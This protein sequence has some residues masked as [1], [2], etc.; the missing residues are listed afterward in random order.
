MGQAAAHVDSIG[1]KAR[2]LVRLVEAG[3][4]VPSFVCVTT[5]AMAEIARALPPDVRRLFAGDEPVD[6]ARAPELADR[7][8]TAILAIGLPGGAERALAEEIER[9]FPADVALAVR[10]SAV[11]EDSA[12]DSFAGQLDTF[13]WVARDAVAARVLDCLAS[14]CSARALLY[15][16]ARLVARPMAAAVVVQRMVESRAAGIMFTADPIDGDRARLLVVAG[17]GLG[18]GVVTDRVATDRYVLSASN[19]TVLERDVAVKRERV[20]PD[21]ARGGTRVGA[22]PD[23]QAAS[24][25]LFDAELRAL[26]DMAR[27]VGTAIGP[28]QDVEWAI[29]QD[30]CLHFLQV[31]PI[32]TIDG[33]QETVFDNANIVE[34]YPGFS[35]PLTFSFARVAYEET[36]RQAGRLLGVPEGVLRANRA[37][38]ANMIAHLRGRIY[39][40]LTSFYRVMQLV[41]GFDWV[42]PAWEK[43]L[44]LRRAAQPPPAT[45]RA[46][47]RSLPLTASV[48][49]RLIREVVTL[50]GNVASYKGLFEEVRTGFEAT[51]LGD[52]D[53]HGLLRL[54]ERLTDRLLRPYAVSVIN[55][56]V[57]QQLF[58]AL[59]RTLTR[60]GAADPSALR[61]DLLSGERA[62]ESL[63]PAASLLAIAAEVRASPPLTALFAETVDDTELWRRARTEPELARL[64]EAILRH[65]TRY[66][67]RTLHELKLE[68]PSAAD[69]P[70]FVVPLIRRYATLPDWAA[71]LGAADAPARRAAE[72]E[73]RRLL[74]RQPFGRL[75]F[76]A[77]LRKARRAVR[78]REDLRLL[79]SRAFGMVKSIF[80]EL[81]RRLVA[82]GVLRDESDVFFLTVDELAGHVRGH[83]ASADLGQLVA[84][85]RAE[86]EL[87][88]RGEPLAARLV[89]RGPVAT[90]LAAAADAA[91]ASADGIDDGPSDGEL[92]RGIGCCPGRARARARIVRD[93]S[94]GV[95]ADGAILVAPLTDPGWVF[96]MVGAAGLVSERG[97]PLS[98]TAII[99]R[100]LRLPTVVAVPRA[101]LSIPD[102]AL[103]EID[104]GAGTVRL[105]PDQE[106]PQA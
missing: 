98:H 35:S 96:L 49:A 69:D 50:E 19:S 29:D 76:F 39:Y 34:S 54:Y 26:G 1:G 27:R 37:V 33:R 57:G 103:V 24:P 90:G 95:A 67:D 48:L 70:T 83:G 40:N 5:R 30:G 73:A 36:F 99:G 87:Q 72:V 74:R 60:A 92:L 71:R 44:G 86:L 89:V 80:R 63:A 10:S 3:I 68:T 81:S 25:A 41:P 17:L 32:T 16:Q 21:R 8:R 62:M 65:G 75:L 82:G 15:R 9:A 79:R 6:A 38:H 45:W 13:L 78:F 104:G 2:G 46:R 77:A 7:A 66:G 55:D 58:E 64:H 52:L 100:E 93:P 88:R 61:S 106:S 97:S 42:L 23:A 94:P 20:E 31:R 47:A 51:P 91:R 85:R 59:G 101:T 43:A 105:L 11:G 14:S 22:V 18:D 102:G 84:L 53:E 12:R 56:L 4:T 28:A